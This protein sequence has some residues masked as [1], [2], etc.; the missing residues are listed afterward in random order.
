MDRPARHPL[1]LRAGDSEC[2]DHRKRSQLLHG[3][4]TAHGR[5]STPCTHLVAP[6][7]HVKNV[8][9]M[10]CMVG[11]HAAE[12]VTAAMA[13]R[14]LYLVEGDQVGSATP[15]LTHI[16]HRFQEHA[17]SLPVLFIAARQPPPVWA[18]HLRRLGTPVQALMQARR[19]HLLDYAALLQPEEGAAGLSGDLAGRQACSTAQRLLYRAATG[20][21]RADEGLLVVVDDVQAR[22]VGRSGRDSM[23][24][25]A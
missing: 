15:L 1:G 13:C 5:E 25:A 12:D 4:N 21:A 17:D 24:H 2:Q 23:H 19:L 3:P 14:H 20:L 22:G 11:G 18:L 8:D 7:A 16:V 9:H 6:R 10:S